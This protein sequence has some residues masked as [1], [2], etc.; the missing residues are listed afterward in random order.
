MPQLEQIATYVSQ[1]FWLVVTFGL[2]YLILWRAALPKVAD[3]L[4]ERQERIDDDLEK[5]RQLKEEA[6]TVLQAYEAAMSGARSQA[7]DIL[8]Q[9]ADAAAKDA[10]QR[11]AALSE[12]LAKDAD[13][14]EA[15]IDAAR[16]EALANVRAV[17]AEAAR[18]ATNRLIGGSIS[19]ADADAAVAK[20]LEGSA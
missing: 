8:R 4:Q 11:H 7:Q 19:E 20:A 6:E 10:E 3:L 1:A 5:A 2:L 17:A 16:E 12:K 9:A 13:A 18:Q 14:A 15:R